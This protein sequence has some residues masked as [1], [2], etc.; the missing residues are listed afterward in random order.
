MLF[1]DRVTTR[2]GTT[3]RVRLKGFDY[4]TPGY[5]FV[6]ICTHDRHHY[7]GSIFDD[8]LSLTP[9]GKMVQETIEECQTH[10]GSVSVDSYVVMPNHIHVLFG[11]SVRLND[12]PGV[13]SLIDVVHWMKST[14]HQRFREGVVTHKWRPY[15]RL[16]WQEGYHD[17][18]VRNE[19]ELETLRAYILTNVAVWEKDRFY[20]GYMD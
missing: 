15:D 2:P 16:V 20:D 6:T 19:R 4:A 7:F 18:I 1:P 10:F 8:D 17:H 13:E 12:E 14:V 11:L 3:R 9:A 5:Y